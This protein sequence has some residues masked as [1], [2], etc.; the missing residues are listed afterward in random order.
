[1]TIAAIIQARMGSTRLPGKVLADLGGRPLLDRVI[2]AAQ[3]SA[4]IDRVVIATTTAPADDPIVARA[5]TLGVA[6]HRGDADDV[7]DRYHGAATAIGAEV[8]VRL[9]ADCPLLDPAVIDRVVGAL[10]RGADYATNTHVR[11]YP[12]GLDVEALHADVLARIHRLATSAAAREHVTAF[13]RERPALFVVRQ[14]VAPHADGELRVTVDT[15]EDLTVVRALWAILD[16]DRRP[17]ASDEVVAALRAR[18][19]LVALNAGVAQV[20]W[21]VSARGPEVHHGQ[22]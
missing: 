2:A 21:H 18:P 14:V 19:E 12:R 4:T 8:V 11:S 20:P 17:P 13:V 15:P 1:M 5:A 3:A 6:C 7:L 16:G 9:T 22:P 10:E